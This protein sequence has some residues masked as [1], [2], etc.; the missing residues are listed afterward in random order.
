MEEVAAQ[1][2]ADAAL[3]AAEEMIT[4]EIAEETEDSDEEAL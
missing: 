3:A 1:R 4:E 2:S